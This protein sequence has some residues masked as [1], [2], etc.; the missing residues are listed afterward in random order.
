MDYLLSQKKVCFFIPD[1]TAAGAERVAINIGNAMA[2]HGQCVEF[3]LM[4]KTGLFM[5]DLHSSISVIDLHI[6]RSPNK[7]YKLKHIVKPL[8]QYIQ[9]T[10]ASS[11]IVF[12]WPLT[13]YAAWV[14]RLCGSPLEVIGSEHTCWSQF[15]GTQNIFKRWR[16]R[17]GMAVGYRFLDK[18]LQVSDDAARDL[19]RFAFLKQGSVQVIYNPYT[20]SDPKV[21]FDRE[22]VQRAW[23]TSSYKILSV[24][25]LSYVKNFSLL[26]DAMAKVRTKLNASLVILGEGELREALEQK[27]KDKN[28]EGHVN[29]MGFVEDVHAYYQEA[30]LYVLSS[31]CEGLPNVLLEAI[32]AGTPV[33]STDCLSGPREILNNGEFGRL[34]PVNNAEYLAASMIDSLCTT[35]DTQRLKKRAAEF[36]VNEIYPQYLEVVGALDSSS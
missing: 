20:L 8:K 33:V 27:I 29:L 21:Q 25:R 12:S 2:E 18:L 19:E 4:E 32:A 35:H 3:I 28:L 1:L 26:L 6:P 9:T 14:N 30:D 34:V 15:V 31:V 36:H 10:D 22:Q 5:Q 11:M 17:L 13:F 7:R 16:K 23:S 24:G